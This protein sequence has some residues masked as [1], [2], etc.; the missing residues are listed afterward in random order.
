MLVNGIGEEIPEEG[1]ERQTKCC[2]CSGPLG[3]IALDGHNP[4]PLARMPDKCCDD[5]NMTKVMPARFSNYQKHLPYTPPHSTDSTLKW[6]RSNW[7][8]DSKKAEQYNP[9][10]RN[11]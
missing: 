7:P 5:C 11:S 8:K 2:L 4:A 6:M 3:P 10:W 9:Q 1:T